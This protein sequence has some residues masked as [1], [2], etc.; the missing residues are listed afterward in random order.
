MKYFLAV[1]IGAGSGRHILG[2]IQDGKLVLEE[3]HRFENGM[4]RQEDGHLTWD[5][6][7]LFR[8]IKAGLKKAGELGKVPSYIAIDTWGVDYVLLDKDDNEILPVYAYRDER[9]EEAVPAVE[10]V[11]A[12]EK[13][14]S[15]TGIQKQNFNT[16]YQLWCD[17]QTGRMDKAESLL[18][19]PEYFCYKLT[20]VKY[21]EYTNA[22][23]GGMLD[24]AK[25]TWS[26]EIIE[27]LGYKKSLFG[28]LTLPGTEVGDLLPSIAEEVGYDAKVILCP[29]HD[30]ASAV[31][32]CPLDDETLFLSSGTWSLI[33]FENP[34]PVI[35]EA[36][37]QANYTNEGGIEYRFRVL[38]NFMGMWLFQSIRKNLD[39]K[40]TYD[41]MME[42]AM[43]SSYDKTVDVNSPNLTAPVSMIEAIRAEVGEPDLPVGDV[44]ECVYQSLSDAYGRAVKEAEALSGR[45]FKKLL[46]VGGGGSDVYLNKLTAEKTGLTIL[47]GIKE[48]TTT[49][50]LASQII[51]DCKANGG[52]Y[53]DIMNFRELVKASFPLSETKG[54]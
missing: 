33:G 28:E 31:A 36:G 3:I 50:N 49:G 45:T 42:M 8:E 1:D 26:D 34:E 13:L 10:A 37:F 25:K 6:E 9:T 44:L 46:I 32:A 48:A 24:A 20:G 16:I 7:R 51:Y 2:S 40:Y 5:H 4:D 41:E 19:I 11:I 12:P 27:T 35:N 53:T 22:S 39:K 30:T 17:K 29:T 23:T 21:N 38:K 47:T 43:A 15:I 14:Y 18:M 52:D 54:H